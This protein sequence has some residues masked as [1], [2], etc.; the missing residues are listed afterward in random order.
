ML[1]PL[2]V[3]PLVVV[4]VLLGGVSSQA[5]VM[6]ALE[7]AGAD[8][9]HLAV[10][11]TATIAVRLSGLE[12]G[13][14]LDTLAATVGFSGSLLGEPSIMAGPIVPDPLDAPLDFLTAE[15]PGYVEGT[16]LT[17]GKTPA[18]RIRANGLFFSFDVSALAPGQ[19]EFSFDFVDATAP[20]P[21][22]PF[23]PLPVT[24]Q[25]SGPVSFTVVPEPSSVLLLA[26]M[27][28]AIGAG[29]LRVRRRRMVKTR[30]ERV[31]SW[32]G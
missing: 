1:R 11:Q 6:L 18:D 30:S 7:S 26:I 12:P 19:G 14:E 20:N 32:S 17:F 21:D 9:G 29:G 10:G 2:R 24:V 13:D 3:A 31:T 23:D 27:G 22:D 15:K 28:A 8:M 4:V 16:F 5:D 25:T